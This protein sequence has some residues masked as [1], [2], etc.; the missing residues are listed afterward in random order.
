MLRSAESLSHEIQDFVDLQLEVSRKKD[1]L[2]ESAVLKPLIRA[3]TRD[4]LDVDRVYL[5]NLN[6][7]SDRLQ[8]MR[9]VRCEF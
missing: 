3:P 7:R 4:S 8:R 2:P 9:Y 6:R 1:F 5:V